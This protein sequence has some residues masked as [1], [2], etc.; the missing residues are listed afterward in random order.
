MSPTELKPST[1]Y[2]ITMLLPSGKIVNIREVKDAT[3]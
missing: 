2:R 3:P 1:W